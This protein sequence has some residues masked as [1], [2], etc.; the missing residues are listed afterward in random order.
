[1]AKCKSK[2]GL[3]G[4]G[5]RFLNFNAAAVE[6]KAKALVEKTGTKWDD[7]KYTRAALAR[8]P[9]IQSKLKKQGQSTRRAM[10][11]FLTNM[12]QNVVA[13]ET[14]DPGKYPY[15][16]Q[17]YEALKPQVGALLRDLNDPKIGWDPSDIQERWLTIFTGGKSGT[18][19]GSSSKQASDA[20]INHASDRKGHQSLGHGSLHG[21]SGV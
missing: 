17:T 3:S 14:S 2:A 7:A 20:R 1:V 15:M 12:E 18:W 8:M 10:A 6:E 4:Y 19:G 5:E 16:R 21:L 13:Y 9:Q 11:Q